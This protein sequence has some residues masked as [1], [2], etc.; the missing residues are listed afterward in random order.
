MPQLKI[1]VIDDATMIRDLVK[2]FIRQNFKDAKVFEAD[3][4]Q[5]AIK[6]LTRQPVDLIL[7]DWEMPQM[8]GEELLKWVRQQENLK[9][10]PFIMVTS[11][12]DREFVQKAIESQVSDYLVKPFNTK[13]FLEKIYRACK[14]HGVVIPRNAMINPP[15]SITGGGDSLSVLTAGRTAINTTSPSK[16]KAA[17]KPMAKGMAL[18]RTPDGEVRCAIKQLDLNNM[19]GIFKIGDYKPHILDQVSLDLEFRQNEESK[20]VRINGFIQAL[21]AQESRPDSERAFISVRF[22][23]EDPQKRALISEYVGQFS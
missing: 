19:T 2:K 4:G 13:Q 6:M 5:N 20:T 1:A 10:K 3:N 16:P 11:R 8:D 23:D 22:V 9:N 21:K 7:C 18:I 14:R 15:S 12:G 17:A